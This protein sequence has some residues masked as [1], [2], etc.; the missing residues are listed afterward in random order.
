MKNVYK[1]IV[2]FLISLAFFN[3]KKDD[4]VEVKVR[5]SK[6][7]YAKDIESIENFLKSHQIII[8]GNNDVSFVASSDQTIWN[9]TTYPLQSI[10]LKSDSR[11]QYVIG[12]ENTDPVTYKIYYLI[13]NSGTGVQPANFDNVFTN[14]SA[15]TLENKL[16]DKNNFGF[17]SSFPKQGN[18]IF[19]E[20]ISGYRQILAKIKTAESIVI[21]PDGTYNAQNPGRV[22]VFI[23]SGMGYF[24]KAKD[25]I[26]AYSPLIFDITLLSLEEID[27]DND[28]ILTKYEDVN[29]DG[30]IWNDD[31]DGDGKPNFLDPDDDADGKITRE[32]ITYTQNGKQLIYEFENIPTCTGGTIK[33]HLDPN[34]K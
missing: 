20:V 31:T 18:A 29:Q 6:E 1:T 13:I 15:Y 19:G 5:D 16:V 23:P 24:D 30:N 3:C 2:F 32:E 28:G 26:P 34:C 14:Y 4:N 25:N 8:N 9:Q 7:V 27:H 22:I 10:E 33:K 17:W 21:N 11:T 12:G